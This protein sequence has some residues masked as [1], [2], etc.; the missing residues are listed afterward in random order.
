MTEP[1][2]FAALRRGLLEH[3][4]LAVVSVKPVYASEALRALADAGFPAQEGTLYPLL[5]KMRRSGLVGYEWRES[6]V[7]PPRKYYSITDSG[8]QQLSEFRAYWSALTALI[9]Q[10]G[11]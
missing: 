11:R 9:E 2:K 5:S 10:I 1:D 6:P 7:G 4:V 3:L 8:Q